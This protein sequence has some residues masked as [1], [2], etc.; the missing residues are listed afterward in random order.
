MMHFDSKCIT[1]PKSETRPWRIRAEFVR[2]I[3]FR[4]PKPV[5]SEMI[6][7]LVCIFALA[8]F[9]SQMPLNRLLVNSENLRNLGTA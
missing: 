9:T 1:T 2:R 8:E 4:K 3:L 7:R 5:E 6:A